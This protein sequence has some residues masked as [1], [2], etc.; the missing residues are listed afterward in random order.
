MS[1]ILEG[2]LIGEVVTYVEENQIDLIVM[3]SHGQRGLNTVLLGSNAQ[4]MIRYSKVP[5]I[6]VKETAET[7]GFKNLVYT[8]NFKE[9][10]LNDSINY[11]KSI[12][13]FYSSNLHLLFINTP[14]HFEDTDIVDKRIESV[15]KTYNIEGASYSTFNSSW[16]EEGIVKFAKLNSPDLLVINTHGFKGLKQLFH[17][18]IA[19][20][21]VN[22]VD[23]PVMIINKV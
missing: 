23:V 8:S 20:S 12:S 10:D 3:G 11:V 22:S 16:V 7:G 6:I 14:N 9:D 2:D 19:E 5:V 15:I 21:V 13:D 4:K 18:S 17:H 1:V